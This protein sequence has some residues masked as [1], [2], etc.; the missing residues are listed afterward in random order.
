M[1]P[2]RTI[3]IVSDIHYAAPA[4][5]ARRGY[6]ANAIPGPLLRGMARAFRRHVWLR[7]P[8]GHNHLLDRFL[9]AAAGADFVVANGDYSCDSAFVGV[10]DD[11]ALSSAS[12]CLG[13]LRQQFP[14]RLAVV[15]GDHELG[16]MSLFGGQGGP[17]LASWQRLVGELGLPPFWH[18][19]FGRYELMGVVSSLVALP[20][21]APELLSG[22]TTAWEELRAGHLAEI[23]RAFAELPPDHRVIL[24]CHDPSAL[25][26]LLDSEPL[27][28]KLGQIELT[29]IG[30][31]HTGW[32]LRLSRMMSGLPPVGF[33]GNS[34]RRMSAALWRARAW[35]PFHVRLCPSLA[36]SEL[37]KDGGYCLLTLDPEALEPAQL[38][39]QAIAR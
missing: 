6:E 16:K 19:S 14:D 20:V 13:K 28:Q 27:R 32:V 31:L 23:S 30:H 34:V 11:A 8:L 38:R 1:P 22:E 5:Q 35:R 2:T 21:F 36:G 29:I 9:A 26:F 4:E 3:A 33:L 24:F 7:D 18:Q 12:L 15:F 37:L 10:G 17:R 39:V 25:P